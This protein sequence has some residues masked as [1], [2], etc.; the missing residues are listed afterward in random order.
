MRGQVGY[1]PEHINMRRCCYGL[2]DFEKILAEPLGKQYRLTA[3][4]NATV[5]AI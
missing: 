3:V 5:Q 2:M 1:A 4:I